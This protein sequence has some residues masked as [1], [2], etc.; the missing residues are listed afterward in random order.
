MYIKPS[1]EGMNDK[2]N[3]RQYLLIFIPLTGK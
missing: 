2:E 1:Y 3:M